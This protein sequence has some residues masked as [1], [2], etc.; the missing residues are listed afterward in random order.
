MSTLGEGWEQESRN[1]DQDVNKYLI[2]KYNLIA[3]I[4]NNF[5]QIGPFRFQDIYR[6]VVFEFNGKQKTTERLA[7][8]EHFN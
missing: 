8:E 3:N 4:P 5:K 6:D 7:L 2:T 1:T